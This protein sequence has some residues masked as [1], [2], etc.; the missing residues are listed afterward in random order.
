MKTKLLLLCSMLI[1]IIAFSQESTIRFWSNSDAPYSSTA[2]R[3]KSKVYLLKHLNVAS[4]KAKLPTAHKELSDRSNTSTVV[5][6]IPTPNGGEASFR[7]QRSQL[8]EPGL[9]AKFPEIRTFRGQ[10]ITDPQATIVL[11]YN[12]NGVHAMVLTPAGDYFIDPAITGNTTD[13]IVYYKK[14]LIKTFIFEEG[15]PI[16]VNQDEPAQTAARA[17]ALPNAAQN[18]TAINCPG[19]SLRKY[20]MAIA[21]TGEYAVAAT[22]VASPTVAQTLS[23]IQTTF[24]RVVGVYEKELA[25]T[26][27]L[28]ANENAVIFTNASTDPFTGNN[29]A[30]TL[31]TESQTVID[32]YITDANYDV[33]HTFSTG[34]GGLSDLGV[35]CASGAKAS[36]ITGSPTPTGD[37]YDIDYVAHEMGHAFGA[38]HTFNDNSN[39]SCSGNYNNTTNNEPGSGSTIMAYAGICT[40]DDLQPH[41]DPYFTAMSFNEIEAY[42]TTG[43]G[44]SCAVNIATTNHPPVVA[45]TADYTIPYKT[46]FVLTGSATDPDGDSLTYCWEQVNVGGTA[47]TWNAPRTTSKGDAPIFRSFT[48]SYTHLTLP[49]IYSV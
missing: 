39:G 24:A 11:D 36:S 1:S 33:G 3:I 16:T 6:E 41:S 28:V 48:V 43:S 17:A 10:G 38:N 29:N 42:N 5:I 9:E 7:V 20:R 14:D 47:C 31:I 37:G 12:L 13:Y 2:L 15:K 19:T 34:G 40:G 26:M 49:T 30:N 23:C 21:C 18:V 22:G 46:P 25:I 44:K 8:M 45:L 32:K 27:V 35:I 4:F